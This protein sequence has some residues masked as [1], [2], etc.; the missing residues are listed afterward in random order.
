MCS[1]HLH[2]AGLLV[3][4]FAALIGWTAHTPAA[5][6]S[7]QGYPAKPVRL[8]V[9]FPAGASSDIVGRLIAEKLSEHL[10]QP[11]I[12]DNR[13]GAGGN[14]GIASAAKSPPDGYTILIVTASLAVAPSVYAK[15]GYD[16]LEDLAPVARLTSIPNVLLVHP[17]VPAKTLRQFIT[18]ARSQ[19]GK[20][21]FGSGGAGTTNHLANELLK[22]LEK[23]DMVHVPYKGVT[24]A[25]V[26]MMS[27]EVDEVVMPIASSLGHIRA[28]KVRALAVLSEQRIP[29]L[30]DVP[31]GIEAGVPGFVMPLWYAMFA[32]AGTPGDIVSRL[33]RDIVRVL[34]S[35]DMRE[36]LTALGVD[37]WPGTPEQ[38]RD[39]LRADIERYRQVVRAARLPR[40]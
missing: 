5:A 26:A 16:P 29:T 39:L 27:G 12:A 28:G 7:A 21:N 34:Q 10:G 31:T 38:L 37:P 1:M 23:I 8:I 24:Q 25:M 18:L 17:S 40:Q 35:P 32:P 13:A 36:R 14:V 30:P 11:I 33:H 2:R 9:P 6:A 20:L 22:H 19:P 15:L 3:A 4:A